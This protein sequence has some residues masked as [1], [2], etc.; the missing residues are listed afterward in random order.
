[1]LAVVVLAV[2]A[3]LAGGCALDRSAIAASGPIDA[4]APGID[5]GGAPVDAAAGED[6]RSPGIDAAPPEDDGGAADAHVPAEDAFVPVD[7]SACVARCE[8]SVAITCPGGSE[9]RRDCAATPGYRCEGAG[10]C[11]PPVCVPGTSTCSPDGTAELRC[12]GTGTGRDTVDCP[13]GCSGAACRAPLP[14][15]Y[16]EHATI[17]SGTMRIAL[18]GAGDEH[19]HAHLGA[20]SGCTYDANG[21]D[22]VL[23]LTVARTRRVVI[24]AVNVPGDGR[25]VDPIIYLQTACVDGEGTQVA[26]NDDRTG[27]RDARIDTTLAAGEYFLVVDS[28]DGASGSEC[29]D[30]DLTVTPM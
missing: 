4:D 6:A 29:G 14:C 17:A 20:S 25:F 8:G 21:Q 5:G 13:R 27:T 7:A 12:N 19:D 3:S 15:A 11:V 2:L 28:I 30:V 18:C 24:D 23:R 9:M 26:C 10:S 1:M 16:P 22:R